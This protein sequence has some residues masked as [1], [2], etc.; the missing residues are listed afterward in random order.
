MMNNDIP[1]LYVAQQNGMKNTDSLKNY[2]APS[3]KHQHKMSNLLSGILDETPSCLNVD[4]DKEPLPPQPP[5][6]Q[7]TNVLNVVSLSQEKK[8]SNEIFSGATFTDCT[9]NFGID[10]NS[11]FQEPKAKKKRLL[12]DSSDED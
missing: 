12:L 2:K 1:D 4:A 11:W 8:S 9:F 10:Y 7:M 3:K 6:P 5:Q